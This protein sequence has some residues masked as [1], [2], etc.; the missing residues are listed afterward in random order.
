[1]ILKTIW[2][3]SFS[4][5]LMAAIKEE[6]M[7][8]WNRIDLHQHTLNEVCFD[9]SKPDSQYTHQKFYDL[10]KYQD[11]KIK[12]VTNHNTL[13]LGDHIKHYLICDMLDV[14]YLLGIEIDYVYDENQRFQAISIFS[15]KNDMIELSKRISGLISEKLISSSSIALNEDDFSTVHQDI[16]FLFIPHA[17]KDNGMFDADE[18][19]LSEKNVY[20]IVD[21]LRNGSA[22]PVLFENTKKYHIYSI[23]NKIKAMI[24][25]NKL[26]FGAYIGSDMNFNDED[27]RREILDQK[28]KYSINAQPTY[29]G[30]EISFLNPIRI[31]PDEEIINR[32][33]F[34]QRISFRKS[35]YFDESDI[36]D[37]SPGLNVI[38]GNSG[39][40]KT[41]LLHQLYKE[42]RGANLQI[43]SNQKKEPPYSKFIGKG[44]KVVL[45]YT[46]KT[47]KVI[48]VIEIPNLYS[49]IIKTKGNSETL[50]RYFNLYENTKLNTIYNNYKS[51]LNEYSFF[52]K[53]C[54]Q[55][56][57]IASTSLTNMKK[58]SDFIKD[59]KISYSNFEIHQSDYDE[60]K[61][62]TLNRN[63]DRLNNYIKRNNEYL[64]EL[65][66]MNEFLDSRF[67]KNVKI[68]ENEILKIN[69]SL[70]NDLRFNEV[71]IQ[72]EHFDKKIIQ[73]INKVLESTIKKLGIKERSINN[74][75]ALFYK[76]KTSLLSVNID[77]VKNS[78]KKKLINLEYPFNNIKN[79][80][81]SNKN[82]YARQTIDFNKN[83]KFVKVLDSRLLDCSG[84]KTII[85]KLDLEKVNFENSNDI[86]NL[87]ETL[88]NK[89]IEL[90]D[91]INEFNSLDKEFEL[92]DNSVG[93]W[94]NIYSV[95]P[96]D[97]AKIYMNYYFKREITEKQPDII[98]IDQPENDVDKCF[99][100]ET[101]SEFL[102]YLK[103]STQIIVTSHDAIIAINSDANMIIKAEYKDNKF[104][105]D[106]F[107]LESTRNRELFG[108]NIVSEILDGGKKNIKERYKIY[109]G[110]LKDE[111]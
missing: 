102:K 97:I 40:G 94:K 101:L 72:R 17:I 91:V 14:E 36:I 65:K 6:V 61:L 19:K 23:Y 99:I 100:T 21:A 96:G 25:E 109:G 63:K 12:A 32:D 92:Y 10:I 51:L 90:A 89:D 39:S 111:L 70:S 85:K 41:L 87:L 82:K 11:V 49:E 3:K 43:F 68:I 83:D 69:S 48:N 42:I 74:R 56:S 52:H 54:L 46:S 84:Y 44:T 79:E 8:Y 58:A 18:T 64:D 50:L 108:T 55:L 30:L 78:I 76:E 4:P 86:K 15:N 110:S 77:Y 45:D 57:K 7:N 98:V 5:L 31:S 80:I 34:I 16:E 107:T 47:K 95:N 22:F 2:E 60:K 66:N 24:G 35:K 9:K 38:I 106:S 105:Y 103:Q 75:K 71:S 62:D 53:E 37:L 26:V 1:M 93:L 20:W 59:N 33:S 29:R 27:N 67:K 13:N 88:L 104:R 73:I 81:N 28:P